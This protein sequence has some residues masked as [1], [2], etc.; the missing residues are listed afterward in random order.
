MPWT[1][2]GIA[3]TWNYMIA[4]LSKARVQK[5]CLFRM[6]LKSSISRLRRYHAN[7][8]GAGATTGAEKAGSITA[9]ASTEKRA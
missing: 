7:L 4:S 6:Q 5:E 2:A 8:K 3:G 9:G 1:Q